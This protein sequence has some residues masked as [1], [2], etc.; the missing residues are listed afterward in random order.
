MTEDKS[1]RP[2]AFTIV[3]QNANEWY[4]AASDGHRRGPYRNATAVL[5]VAATEVLSARQQGLKADILVQD[6]HGYPHLCRIMDK[7]NGTERCFACQRSW[8]TS[9][10]PLPPRCPLWE[11]LA[12]DDSKSSR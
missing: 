11:A 6:D 8:W 3:K 4:I 2:I 9:L 7:P 5:Q 10:R 1:P 12:P